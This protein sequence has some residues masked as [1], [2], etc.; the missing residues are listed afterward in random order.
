MLYIIYLINAFY[1]LEVYTFYPYSFCSIPPYPWQLLICSSAHSWAC[2]VVLFLDSNISGIIHMSFWSDLHLT[3]IMPFSPS[4]LLQL[5]RFLLFYGWTVVHCIYI[6]HTLYPLVHQ[7]VLRLPP[8]LGCELT[9]AMIWE[10]CIFD[11]L[12]MCRHNWDI[13]WLIQPFL[14]SV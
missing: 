8:C 12:L 10:V 4:V 1:N 14:Q 9:A 3:Y 7:W 2:F 6:H 13:A 11:L 5:T